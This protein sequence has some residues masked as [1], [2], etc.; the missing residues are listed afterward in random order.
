M[1]RSVVSGA[2]VCVV[3]AVVVAAASTVTEF[4]S[5]DMHSVFKSLGSSSPM[6]GVVFVVLSSI[7]TKVLAPQEEVVLEFCSESSLN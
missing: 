7:P 4:I 6:E 3:V 2:M 5:S 1:A